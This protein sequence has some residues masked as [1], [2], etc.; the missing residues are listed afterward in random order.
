MLKHYLK[1]SRR[2]TGIILVA[3]VTLTAAGCKRQDVLV[4]PQPVVYPNLTVDDQETGKSILALGDNEPRPKLTLDDME[5]AIFEGCGKRGWIPVKVQPGVADA[6]L[7]LRDHIAVVRITFTHERFNIQYLS[8]DN[9][10]HEIDAK[11]V[12]QIHPNYNSW[13]QNLK[14]DIT[15]AIAKKTR[16]K[17]KAK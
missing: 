13:V 16:G 1:V 5:T 3:M 11:G 6:T 14:N 10:N 4:N 12:E 7:R 15:L 17:S 8:S 9:L 2:L